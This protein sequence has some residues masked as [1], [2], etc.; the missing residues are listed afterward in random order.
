M[1]RKLLTGILLS[2]TLLILLIVAIGLYIQQTDQPLVTETEDIINK[3]DS[4]LDEYLSQSSTTTFVSAETEPVVTE[5]LVSPTLSPAS[6]QS[7]TET[8]VN[9]TQTEQTSTPSPPTSTSAGY[10]INDEG[11]AT[12]TVT[13]QS[14]PVNDS[15]T[16]TIPPTLTN[17]LTSTPISQTGWEG[18]WSVYWEQKDGNFTSG[19][20]NIEIDGSD[21]MA[22]VSI[23]EEQYIFEGILNEKQNIAVGSWSNS[24]ELGNFY[25]R[26]NEAGLFT[27]NLDSQIGFCGSRMES[28]MPEPCFAVPS[29]K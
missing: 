17:A 12:A 25:W 13:P 3:T 14:Y 20:M 1:K 6:T 7:I 5:P 10:P 9:P 22:S 15:N 26:M 23:E 8:S 28:N 24:Q 27:G 19:L 11:T 21:L 16:S 4:K 2:Y 29:D 18:E